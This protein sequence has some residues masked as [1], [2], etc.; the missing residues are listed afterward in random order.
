MSKR[1][2][3]D[4]L[5]VAKNATDDDIKKAYRKL[6]SA[7]HPDKHTNA[8]EADRKEHEEKFK[9]AKEAYEMLSDTQKRAA[10]DQ[11][12]HAAFEQQRPSSGPG[13]A[14]WQEVDPNDLSEIL[15]QMRAGAYGQP[16][17]RMKQVFEFNAKVTLKDAY[18]GFDV[19]VQLPDGKKHM[20]KVQPGTPEGYRTQHD[21]DENY[22]IVAVTRIRDNFL[23]KDP[24]NCGFTPTLVEGQ[25]V[26][27]LDVGDIE[28]VIQADA[29]DLILGAW[30]DVTDF[31][32]ET[33]KVRIPQGFNQNQR[34][35]V[36]GKGYKH[37]LHELKKPAEGRADLYIRVNP[38][39][40]PPDKLDRDKIVALEA[41]TRP[42]K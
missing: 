8:V 29:L 33:L 25:T 35:K 15:R 16:F 14:G 24:T 23:I 2:Y 4:I 40:N 41:I 19:E 1:D 39:F 38:I 36:K 5:G 6:S 27:R 3:Y 34:L 13:S 30:V 10:Y 22:T 20:V 11:R 42:T 21:V 18:N 31:L 17:R 9:E 12:G 26:M 7:H 32:G 37:W 28:T